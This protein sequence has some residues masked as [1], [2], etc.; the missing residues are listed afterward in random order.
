MER[1]VKDYLASKKDDP[2]RVADI[3]SQD[4]NGCYRPLFNFPSWQYVGVDLIPGRNVDVVLKKQYAWDE[5]EKESFDVV[6]SGQAFEHIEFFWITI[7]EIR[8]IM[9]PG[10]LCCLIAP[11]SGPEHRYPMDCWRFYPD[12]LRALAKYAGLTVLEVYAQWDAEE[13]PEMD[14]QW[15][16]CVLIAQRPRQK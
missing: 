11:S 3:G 7:L 15:Q 5:L 10:G 4:V 8:R 13:Y 6:V 1:F 14:I 2:F 12:G 9:K 16:D